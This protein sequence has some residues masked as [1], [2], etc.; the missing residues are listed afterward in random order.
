VPEIR[1]SDHYT[2]NARQEVFHA[3]TAKYRLYGGAAGG[4]KSFALLWE[5][6]LHCLQFPGCNVLLLRREFTR[7]ES[8]LID[9]FVKYIPKQIYGDNYSSQKHIVKFPNGSTLRFGHCQ[10]EKDVRNYQGAE[11]LFIGFDELTEFTYPMW[12][13][14]KTRNRCP[15]PGTFPC[16]A[17][18]TNPGGVGHA[19][20]KALWIE[21]K[22]PPGVE[23]YLYKPDEYSFTPA[24]LWD[25]PIYAQDSSY[26]ATLQS[27][28][29][30]LRA[31]MLDGSWDLFAGQYFDIFDPAEN[32]LSADDCQRIIQPWWTRWIS[33]DW[34]FKH[35]SAI[36]WHAT[37]KVNEQD[38][39]ITYREL[40]L[41]K[42]SEGALAEEI[43]ART[44]DEKIRRVFLSPD[45]F[46][47]RTSANTI[48]SKFGDTLGR[49]SIPS[50]DKADDD[51][52][53]GWRLLYRKLEDRSWFIST[54]CPE[55]IKAIPL[56]IHDDKHV[57][58]VKK[59]EEIY[60]DVADGL[61]YGLKTMLDPRSKPQNIVLQ[62]ALAAAPNY[63]QAHITHMKLQERFKKLN[64]PIKRGTR[65]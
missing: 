52:V 23:G 64:G 39:V 4:G 28:A 15:I 45:A 25:N 11:Y 57:E 30:E 34:G 2:P 53:G 8:G 22:S 47:E 7:L 44:S 54:G 42:T 14:L 6:I 10:H 20:V 27:V 46:A 59:T 56:L 43:A 50:P 62:E 36:H 38:V 24:K 16:M 9:H 18:A 17:G 13:F 63:T 48:A 60:D 5:A 19:W 31:A 55:A 40:L 1:I 3:D 26:L 65:R 33:V 29:P 58:D 37:G 32:T 21:Q 41:N 35:H 61:R 12:D 49:Y 51:R